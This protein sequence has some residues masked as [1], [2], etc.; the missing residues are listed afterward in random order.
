MLT[1]SELLGYKTWPNRYQLEKDY[2]QY[3]VLLEIFKRSKGGL[4]FKGGTALQKCYGLDRFSEDLDFTTDSADE[5]RRVEDGLQGIKQLY[6]ATFKRTENEQSALFNLKIEGPLFEKQQSIQTIII[7][8]SKR[9]KTLRKPMLIRLIPKYRDL[10]AQL[11][12]VMDK[13]EILAE[14][15]RALLTRRRPR[16]LYDTYFLLNKGA[17]IDF[18][19]INKKLEY[20]STKFDFAVLTARITDLKA[21]WDKELGILMEHPP[22]FEVTAEFVLESFKSDFGKIN[23]Y[24]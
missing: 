13:D 15:T 23:L 19:L 20:Y 4:V 22:D 11:V 7:E 2:L 12:V 5:I 9:E 21:E 17:K 6:N 10:E 14:K 16:D 24:K 18:E 1:K 8:I 3:A